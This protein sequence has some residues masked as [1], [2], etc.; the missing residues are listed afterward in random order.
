MTM[1]GRSKTLRE[2]KEE[3]GF[4]PFSCLHLRPKDRDPKCISAGRCLCNDILVRPRGAWICGPGVTPCSSCAY[5]AD[6]L[7]DY[8]LGGGKTCDAPLCEDHALPPGI[9]VHPLDDI[10]SRRMPD[11]AATRQRQAQIVNDLHFC[12]AHWVAMQK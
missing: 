4:E 1:P 7:C 6:Y 10:T 9:M 2:I 5:V 8:P 12:P 3:A 11:L